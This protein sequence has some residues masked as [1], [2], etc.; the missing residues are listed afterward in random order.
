MKEKKDISFILKILIIII[1]AGSILAAIKCIFVGLQ[2]D[3]EYA[4]T[5]SYRLLFGDRLL[6]EVWDPHQTSAFLLSLIE[7]LFIKLTGQ[8][9]YLVL[10][11]RIAGTLIHAC[12]AFL[13]Y[14]A[15]RLYAPGYISFVLSLVWFGILPKDSVI[16]EF[17]LM[18]AWFIALIA[19]VLIRINYL[20]KNSSK[21]ARVKIMILSALLSAFSFCLVLSYPTCI[22]IIPFVYLFL[23]LDRKKNPK[24]VLLIFPLVFVLLGLGYLG[25]LLSYMNPAEMIPVGMA[26]KPT[27]RNVIIIPSICPATVIG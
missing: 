8:T 4:I 11:C 15:V 6:T 26:T 27:P 2:R 21:K 24:A 19:I 25:Y 9:T 16:P 10:W 13:L 12:I 20:G 14:K 3:E 17:S 22:I 23:I 5:L 18:M 7:W 1:A